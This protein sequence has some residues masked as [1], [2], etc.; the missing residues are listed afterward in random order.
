MK[1]IHTVEF[2]GFLQPATVTC[3]EANKS[4]LRHAISLF[5]IEMKMGIPPN[6]SSSESFLVLG[7]S[8]KIPFPP[9]VL[10]ASPILSLFI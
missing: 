6:S 7:V 9:Y 4:D 1:F 10:R 2:E 8:T 3:P 5:I